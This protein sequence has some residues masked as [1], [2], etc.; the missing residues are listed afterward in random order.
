MLLAFLRA[1]RFFERMGEALLGEFDTA[2]NQPLLVVFFG[3]E[4][5][6]D[7]IFGVGLV[8]LVKKN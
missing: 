7:V 2:R 8:A 3:R 1:W 4:D 6:D 5:W